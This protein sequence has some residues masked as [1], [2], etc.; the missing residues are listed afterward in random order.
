MTSGPSK[1]SAHDLRYMIAG[2]GEGELGPKMTG[3]NKPESAS[4]ENS[5]VRKNIKGKPH[6]K[7]KKRVS[8]PSSSSKI[9]LGNFEKMITATLRKSPERLLEDGEFSKI[10]KK[11][12]KEIIQALHKANDAHVRKQRL[13]QFARCETMLKKL[14]DKFTVLINSTPSRNFKRRQEIN[15]IAK[16]VKTLL[17]QLKK[18][19]AFVDQVKKSFVAVQDASPLPNRSNEKSEPA[20]MP[21]DIIGIMASF[22]PEKEVQAALDPLLDLFAKKNKREAAKLVASQEAAKGEKWAKE[23][24]AEIRKALETQGEKFIFPE[25]LKKKVKEVT[26]LDLSGLRVPLSAKAMKEICANWPHITDLN[27]ARNKMTQEIAN[28]LKEFKDLRH[29]NLYATNI[30][31]DILAIVAQCTTLQSLNC[32]LCNKITS[33]GTAQK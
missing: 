14:D 18:E 8:A 25:E 31:N 15:Q 1:P 20:D 27:L 10:V 9:P 7:A 32:G 6:S 19:D 3:R 12:T 21:L 4:V 29:L 23:V 24:S 28:L 30:N 33:L 17:L 2:E 5:S 13:E 22:L 11:G 16:I 26:S